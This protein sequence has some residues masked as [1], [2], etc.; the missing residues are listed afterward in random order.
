MTR[1]D[2]I[3]LG[4]HKVRSNEHLMLSYLTEF[5]ALFGRKPKCAG[6][7]FKTDWKRFVQ[8]KQTPKYFKMKTSKQ[9]ELEK[10]AKSIIHTY[11]IGKIPYRS[12]GN[13]MTEDFAVSYLTNGTKEEIE[14]RKKHFKTLPKIEA[15]KTILVDGEEIKLSEAVGRQLNAYAAEN[16]IDFGDAKKV[17]EKR[18]VIA[19]TL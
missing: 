7:T 5:E 12:R 1:E 6:C 9:F 17:D 14:Q 8:G 13:T 19:K 16:N 10:N 2:L 3:T 15:D 18:A 4:E 11:K